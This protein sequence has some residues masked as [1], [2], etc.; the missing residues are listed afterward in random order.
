MVWGECYEEN[1][2]KIQGIPGNGLMLGISRNFKS[3]SKYE[4]FQTHKYWYSCWKFIQKTQAVLNIE[5]LIFHVVGF[6][7]SISLPTK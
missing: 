2:N 7:C 5:T 4:S 3:K 1:F 6:G